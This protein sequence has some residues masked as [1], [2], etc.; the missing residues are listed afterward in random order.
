MGFWHTGYME[1]H[2]AEDTDDHFV[3]RTATFD[4]DTCG[5]TLAT[6]RDLNVHLFE[7]HATVRP[8]LIYRGRECGRSRLTITTAT[9]PEDWVIQSADQIVLNSVPTT[10]SEATQRLS[11]AQN[12]VFEVVLL[13]AGIRQEFAFEFALA[14]DDDLAGIDAE[15]YDLIQNE[16]LSL[17]S[18]DHFI[19][20]SREFKSAIKYLD[21][22]ANYLYG[23]YAIEKSQKSQVLCNGPEDYR[24]KFDRSVDSLKHFDRGPAEA[25]C[26]LVAFHYNDFRLAMK[27]T[28]SRRIA[29]V[30][31]RLESIL[32]NAPWDTSDLTE[33]PDSSL[34]HALSDSLIEMVVAWCGMPLDGSAVQRADDLIDNIGAQRTADTFKLHLIAAEH[35]L[36]TGDASAA[37]RQA[38]RIR[39]S[40]GTETWYRSLRAR[41]QGELLL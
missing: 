11:S 35:L 21:G 41:A 1:F 39:D 15:V 12:G 26:G 17:T 9:H 25:V 20:R 4:C 37:L 14:N 36:A 3:T 5:A 34:D 19:T 7:G 18:I 33:S 6:K 8:L 13:K 24:T 2:E 10:E 23:V 40:R 28:R 32:R 27:K 30:S 22:I 31:L 29:E 38:D 16:E